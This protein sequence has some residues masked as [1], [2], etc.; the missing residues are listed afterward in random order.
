MRNVAILGLTFKPDVPDLRN[1]KVLD[2]VSE[3]RDFGIEP[4]LYD[5][6]SRRRGGG[7]DLWRDELLVRIIE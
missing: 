5:P 7:A 2:I 6:A 3:L 4:A 1:S